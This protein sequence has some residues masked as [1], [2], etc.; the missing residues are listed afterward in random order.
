MCVCT[1]LKENPL[2]T[3]KAMNAYVGRARWVCRLL[4]FTLVFWKYADASNSWNGRNREVI[5]R[6]GRVQTNRGG[7]D[8][9]V[10]ILPASSRACCWFHTD[11]DTEEVR[12]LTDIL[13]LFA[14]HTYSPALYCTRHCI[15]FFFF[16]TRC[17]F[18]SILESPDRTH[19]HG[20]FFF[21]ICWSNRITYRLSNP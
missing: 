20:Y 11:H 17:L 21:R 2:V 15:F 14:S 12:Y 5:H 16:S 8:L 19:F 7:H 1:Y 13:L 6:G 3:A 18:I 4:A 9:L 10:C